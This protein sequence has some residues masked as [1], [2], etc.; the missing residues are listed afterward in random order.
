L[1]VVPFVTPPQS[2][3]AY[4]VVYRRSDRSRRI[5]RA[6]VDWIAAEMKADAARLARLSRK[7]RMPPPRAGEA[8]R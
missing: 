3:G 7:S 8:A 2:A 6:F 1:L 4:F 5:V